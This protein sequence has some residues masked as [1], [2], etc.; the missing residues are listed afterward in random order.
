LSIV[1]SDIDYR[2]LDEPGELGDLFGLVPRPQSRK[3][4]P[5]ELE[6]RRGRYRKQHPQI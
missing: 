3:L 2:A 4:H 6:L 5:P 1:A